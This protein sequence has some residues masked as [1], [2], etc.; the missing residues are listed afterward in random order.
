MYKLVKN[1][2]IA[3]AAAV[4][5]VVLSLGGYAGYVVLSYSRIG[6]VELDVEGAASIEKATLGVTYKAV[7]YNIGYGAYSQDFTFFMDTGYDDD[8]NP[9]VGHYATAKSKEEV[10]FN[11]SGAITTV[12][13]ESP[14][15]VMFQ[16]VDTDSTRSCHYDQ[17]AVIK[18]QFLAYDHTHAVNYHT[19]FLPYPLYD[20]C[21]ASKAG[22]TTVSRIKIKDAQRKELAVSDS[23]SKLL[24]LDRCFAIHEIDVENGK[25]FY[26]ANIHMS[27]YDEGGTVRQKQVEQ[28]NDF[29]KE[30]KESGDYVIVGGDF[31]HDL[32]THNPDYDYDEINRPFGETKKEPEWVS[33]WFD[34]E[35]NPLQTEGYHMIVSDNTPSFRNNDIEWEEG[36]SYVGCIDGFIVSENIQV[37][38]HANIK[39]KNGNKEVDGF[40]FSDHDP[41]SLSFRLV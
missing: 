1:I 38:K 36:K 8:G 16:E 28:L 30:K 12:R 27:T 25:K 2:L 33:Y 35:Q 40:A 6:D 23:L 39:T 22:L 24:D 9:T 26:L 10:K 21:G 13:L 5:A 3:S 41:A 31:N 37:I 15:F 32:L 34:E 17:D 18:S 14:D 11:I 19:A 29:L 20:M 4:G 7:S